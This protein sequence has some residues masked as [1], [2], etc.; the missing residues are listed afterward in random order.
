AE[1]ARKVLTEALQ[2]YGVIVS[3]VILHEHR[4]H[5]DYEQVIH[6]RKLA[7]QRAQ[8]LTSEREAA[9]QEALRNLET[10][11]GEVAA[12]IAAAQGALEQA[13]LAAD[14]ELFQQQQNADA[15]VAERAAKAKAIAKRN[16]ALRGSGG[17][18]MVKL[19]VAEALA[20]KSIVIVPSGANGI[21]L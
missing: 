14:A 20:G 11:R 4:F 5:P 1:E 3:Q 17:R 7:E 12:D 2:T 19:R 16:E 21:G 8:Q 10:A 18:A 15:I 13:K 9:G 6:D